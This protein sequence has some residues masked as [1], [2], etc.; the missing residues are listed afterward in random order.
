LVQFEIL[1]K[2]VIEVTGYSGQGY[3]SKMENKNVVVEDFISFLNESCSA[4]HA[5]E[6]ARKRLNAA[7]FIQLDETESW[8]LAAGNKYYFVRN[9][10]TLI[11]FT[12]GDKYVPGNGF[13][14]IGAHSDRFIFDFSTQ[15]FLFLHSPCLK[16]KPVACSKKSEALVLNTQPYG[17]G[18]WHTWFD[19]DLGISFYLL[20]RYLS[21]TGIKVLLGEYF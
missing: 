17:G 14:V 6:A 5:I 13:T 9:G 12:V 1:E 19:R 10:T 3:F 18:L 16:V 21:T 8:N 15:L 20:C 7:G 11:A 4:F 2:K